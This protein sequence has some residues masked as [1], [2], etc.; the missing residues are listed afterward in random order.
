MI[1]NPRTI[2]KMTASGL[3]NMATLA[4]DAVAPRFDIDVAR[5][6]L[7]YLRM[8]FQEGTGDADLTIYQRHRF[9]TGFHDFPLFEYTDIG[10]SNRVIDLRIHAD[11][12]MHYTFDRDVSRGVMDSIVPVWA[13]PN[14]GTMRWAIEVGLV[15][16]ELIDAGPRQ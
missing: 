3:G 11:E 8:V 7:V 5:F 4:D 16:V 14:S 1:V 12:L 13:N 10:E 6:A 2:V 9:R 15:D